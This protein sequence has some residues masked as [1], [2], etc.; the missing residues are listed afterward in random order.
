MSQKKVRVRRKD[1]CPWL[2]YAGLDKTTNDFMIKT[3]ISK[4]TCNKT[5]RNYLCNAKFLAK[6]FRERIVEQPNII[7][8]KLQELIRKKF[9][10]YVGKTTVRK[11]KVKVLKEIMGDH[12]VEF[13]RILDYKDELLRIN[14]GTSCVIKLGEADE[15]DKPKFQTFH[16]CFDALKKAWMLPLAWAVVEKENT[17]TWT[18]F[19]RCIRDDLRLGE[20]DG[21]TLITDMQKLYFNTEVK[22]DSVDNNMSEYFNGW[23]LAAR[24]KTIITMLEEIRVKMMKR[25]GTLREFPNTWCSNYSPMCLKILEE[26]INRSMDC[27]IEFNGVAGFEVKEGF[28]QHPVDIIKS[29]CSCRLWQLKGIPCAHGV[30]A[31]LFKKHPLYDYIK[32]CYSKETYLRTYANVLEPLTNMEIRPVLSNIIVAPPKIS[33]LSGMPSKSRKKKARETKKSEKLPR[34][35]LAMTYSL[36][37]VRGHNKRGCPLR[38]Q[39]AEPSAAPS[40]TPTGSNRGRGRP[41]IILHLY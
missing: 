10:L 5:T 23:I 35:G 12:I 25:I 16:I 37:H 40:T 39:S 21:L 6:T 7:V 24:H 34:T 17:N 32:S 20:S 11:S 41:K 15:E 8:F 14:P 3:Y 38:G 4:H 33:T 19:V 9:K 1:G 28:C 2:L 29:T 26:N 18:W 27:T 13:G 31:L 36:C 22:C 30:A